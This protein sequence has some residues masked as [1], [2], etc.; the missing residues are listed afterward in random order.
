[1]MMGAQER[2]IYWYHEEIDRRIG[3]ERI[4]ERLRMSQVLGGHVMPDN[5]AEPSTALG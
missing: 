4:P 3:T 1:M 2:G 5:L